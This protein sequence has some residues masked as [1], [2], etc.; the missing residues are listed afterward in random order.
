MN[1]QT[2]KIRELRIPSSAIL[3]LAV[4][5]AFLCGALLIGFSGFSPI[6]AYQALLFGTFGNISF[7]SEVLVKTIPLLLAGL[8][9]TVSNRAQVFSIGA[10]GQIFLGALGAA[11]VGLFLGPLPF[12]IAIP[13]S[14]AMGITLGAFWGGLAGWLKVKMNA[15]EIITTLMMN[16]VAIDLVGYLVSGPWR[17]PKT[18]EPF[19]SQITAGAWLPV[20]IPQTRL[21]FGLIIALAVVALIWWLLHRT[22]LGYQL[23][24]SGANPSA[25]EVNGINVGRMIIISMLISGGLAGL[26]GA[27]ELMGIHHRL[28][29]EVSP[30]FGYTAIIIAV[31]GRGKPVR[32][33]FA[34]FFFAIL[35]VGADGMRRAL[36]IPVS[37]G[38]ILQAL[39]LLFALGS[40][41]VE[42]RMTKLEQ[43]RAHA[44]PMAG[45]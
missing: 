6:E 9:L 12:Y 19:T 11:I 26:A 30:G 5:M 25:A 7:F 36:G 44:E 1:T 17:D 20:L 14:M 40:E 24:V 4:L 28:I 21:H 39:V 16:Y 27:T 33:L 29:E 22:V 45:G 35:T 34:S 41:I 15:N 32:V 8:G 10:E 42:R 13:L 37:V 31:L 38:L 18:V 23:T 43:I 3:P 2:R